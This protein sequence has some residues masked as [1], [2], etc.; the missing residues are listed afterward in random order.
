MWVRK[1]L[2]ITWADLG[3]GMIACLV[4]RNPKVV[5]DRVERYWSP[6][7]DAV[8]C[9]SI[10]SGFDLLLEALELPHGSEVLMSAIT[11]PDMA[12][13]LKDHRL[14]PVPADLDV[15]DLSLSEEA[16][17][18]A[19]GP[20]TRAIVVAHLFGGRMPMEPIVE[21]AR[22]HDLLVIE[23]CAQAYDG[24]RYRGHDDVDVSM[25]SF[26]PIKTATALGGGLLR[27]RDTS[28]RERIR[29]LQ[30]GYRVQSRWHFSGRTAKYSLLKLLSLR[31]MF[32]ILV[33]LCRATRVDYGKLING[34]VHGFAVRDFFRRIRRRPSAPLLAL[35]ERRLETFDHTRASR[36]AA[37]GKLLGRLL[38]STIRCPGTTRSPHTHWVFPILTHRST[39]ILATLRR[40]GFDATRGESLYVVPPPAGRPHLVARASMAALPRM[41]FLPLCPEMPPGA[42]RAMA[43]AVRSLQGPASTHH[44][45]RGR[46][47]GTF[48]FFNKVECPLFLPTSRLTWR[49]YRRDGRGML[50]HRRSAPRHDSRRVFKKRTQE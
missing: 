35:L 43:R 30:E 8:A 32:G 31:P 37:H 25:F 3:F 46:K 5:Q 19:C 15:D 39:E 26:G 49:L 9:L 29:S 7:G 41:V 2:D 48:C 24:G 20:R 11:I 22:R 1:R 50:D 18:L 17:D 6:H 28:I 16:L 36:Q 14:V 12:R 42:I 13:I 21:F 23:D 33:F 44:P 34:S 45:E 40:N 10:R 27:V 38:R 47:K 4:K